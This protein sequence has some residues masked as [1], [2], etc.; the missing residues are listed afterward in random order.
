MKRISAQNKPAKLKC[1]VWKDVN[2]DYAH[3]QQSQIAV[4]GP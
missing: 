3:H 1:G 2:R 4:H